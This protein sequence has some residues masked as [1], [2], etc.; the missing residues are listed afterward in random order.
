MKARKLPGVR[1]LPRRLTRGGVTARRRGLGLVQATGRGCMLL[2]RGA[3]RLCRRVLGCSCA[4]GVIA[5]CDDRWVSLPGDPVIP[6][7]GLG[8]VAARQ[9][10]QAPVGA[11][12]L[13]VRARTLLEQLGSAPGA[14]AAA[15]H[16]SGMRTGP[17]DAGTTPVARYLSAVVCADPG[18]RSV[19]CDGRTARVVRVNGHAESLALP[20]AVVTFIEAFEYGCYPELHRSSRGMQRTARRGS[21]C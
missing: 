17:R 6:A 15:L 1:G 8:T 11:S 7:D 19:I 10:P 4:G 2:E 20:A 12:D 13:A 14:V 3:A 18:V 9:A 16:A 5:R 21:T